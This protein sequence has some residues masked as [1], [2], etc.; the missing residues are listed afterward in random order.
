V[1]VTLMVL[2]MLAIGARVLP[3]GSVTG[4]RTSISSI[5]FIIDIIGAPFAMTDVYVPTNTFIHWRPGV[6][7]TR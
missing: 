7:L 5:N 2:V 6:V 3:H 1:V 4:Q